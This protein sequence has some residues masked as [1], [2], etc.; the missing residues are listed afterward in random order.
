MSVDFKLIRPLEIAMSSVA[1]MP[2]A[3]LIYGLAYNISGEPL[4]LMSVVTGLFWAII[5]LNIFLRY[6]FLKKITFITKHDMAIVSNGFAVKKE[7]VEKLTDE[8]IAK[9][10][11]AM[12][13]NKAAQ[14]LAGLWIEFRTFPV[15][16][17]RVMGPLAGYLIGSNAVVGFKE[18][19]KETAM[20]HEQGHK[21]HEGF[22]GHPD[23]DKCHQFMQ[24]HNLE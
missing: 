11:T 9:W 7:D 2:T 6:S 22:I 10:N 21:I 20:T 3:M 15:S 13:V 1:L 12:G 16:H 4:I 24:E 5:L 8:T 14:S 17:A 18:N 23:N 19:L